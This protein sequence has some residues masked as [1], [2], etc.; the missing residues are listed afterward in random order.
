LEKVKAGAHWRK[1]RQEHIEES[2]GRSTLKK[3]AIVGSVLA[4]AFVLLSDDKKN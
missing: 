4:M 1:S 2:Q 3:V